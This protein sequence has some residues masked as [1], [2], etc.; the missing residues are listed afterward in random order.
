MLR[1]IDAMR[2]WAKTERQTG[3]RLGLVPTMGALHRGHLA[4]VEEAQRRV[5]RVVVSIFVNPLQFGP[6]EDLAQ[7]PRNLEDDL[8]QLQGLNVAAVFLPDS[9]EM[10]PGGLGVTRVTIPGLSEVLCGVTRPTHFNGVATVVAKLFHIVEPNV[11]V[12]GEKDWQQLVIIRRMVYDLNFRVSIVG[13]PTVRA[14]NGLALSSRNRYLTQEELKKATALYHSL[15][16]ARQLYRQGER[17]RD[18]LRRVVVD[19]L[20]NAGLSYEYIELVNPLTLQPSPEY[21]QGPTL[22]AL[23]VHVGSARLIDN[24][25]LGREQLDEAALHGNGD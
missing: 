10:Y 4:L 1:T 24:A 21:L 18:A 2:D 22:V 14:E 20:T 6:A 19:V 16:E 12:F 8:R 7:Y 15:Q 5:N 25:I 3:L 11:A 17:R 13:V 9:D 23:A